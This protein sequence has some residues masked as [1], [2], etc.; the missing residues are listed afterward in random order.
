M[1]RWRPLGC[2]L[3][4]ALFLSV[5]CPERDDDDSSASS[6]QADDDDDTTDDD[7]ISPTVLEPLTAGE[8]GYVM[9]GDLPVPSWRYLDE[10]VGQSLDGIWSF[11]EDPEN[12][13]DGQGWF[14]PGFDRSA[15]REIEVPGVWNAAFEDLFHYKGVA[16]YA[17]T[18]SWDGEPAPAFLR[19]GAAFLKSNIYLN[20]QLI[21]E[22]RGGYTP[23]HAPLGE[24]LQTGENL[25][26]V[27]VDNLIGE[28]TIPVVTPTS[29]GLHGWWPYGGLSRSVTLHRLPDP[30]FFKIEPRFA[31]TD[32]ALSV[33]LGVRAKRARYR[34]EFTWTLT[35]PAGGETAGAAALR[36]PGPGVWFYRL[37]TTADPPLVWSRETPENLY[38]FSLAAED[39]GAAVRF[40]YRTVALDGP[41]FLLNG[42]RDFWWGINRHSDY[43]DIGSVETAAAVEREIDILRDLHVNHVR[44]GHYPVAPVLLDALCDA[45]FTILE[46]IPAYQLF[47][48]QMDDPVLLEQALLQLG[49]MIERDK[50]NP[51]ILS[52]S[53]GNESSTYFPWS[54]VMVGALAD[55]A[56]R[57]DPDRPTTLVISNSPCIVPL[58]FSAPLVDI[59]GVN[60]YYGWYLGSVESAGPCLDRV[61][62]MFPELVIVASEFGAGAVYGKHL[63]GEPG[64]EPLHDHSYTEE[65]QV[66]FL[67]QQLQQLLQRDILTGVMPWVLADFHMEWFP[68]TGDPH[69]VVDTNLKGLLTQ[70]RAHRK[71]AFGL[72]ADM[73]AAGQGI[74][75]NE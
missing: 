49:E 67:Q 59:L 75:R 6:G 30:W 41:D 43:A 66:W 34:A 36:I 47:A 16:W 57:L 12:V 26:V 69:P 38:L 60:Q 11:Q 35:S 4:L 13:G 19:I 31:G 65:W 74:T 18:F 33:M 53:V 45:G 37:A 29:G 56:R 27:R 24:A 64:P 8:V 55:E 2:M 17:V 22:H 71:L 46:E 15:W 52:W 72:V 5:A 70:D 25:L 50:N 23:V 10:T 44:P 68:S 40:G 9:S 51:A 73:Y 61:A 1:K 14:R 21:G 28:D 7:D 42:A 48:R 63:E 20:G 58:E 32:G 62:A 39:D 3:L 54:R